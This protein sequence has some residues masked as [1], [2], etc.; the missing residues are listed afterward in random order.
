MCCSVTPGQTVR[1]S[2]TTLYAAEVLHQDRVAHV[3]GYQNRAEILAEPPARSLL[4]RI[5]DALRGA[6][7]VPNA[8]LLPFPAE[9]RSMTASNVV[10]TSRIPRVLQ[11]LALAVRPPTPQAKGISRSLA[12][13]PASV[14]VFEAAGIYTVVLAEDAREIPGALGAVRPERRPPLNAALFDAYAR[15]YPGWTMALC[16]FNNTEAALALPLVWWYRPA[17]P[18][19]LFLPG[20]DA[21]TGDLPDLGATVETDHTLA[22]S[23]HALTKGQQV[24]YRDPLPPEGPRW[25]LPRALGGVFE[26]SALNGDWYCDTERL[27]AGTLELRRDPPRAQA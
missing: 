10:D 6:S 1:F 11:D 27:R 21:H 22:V 18:E 26:G 23:S 14:Q 16:C 15:W 8:M 12:L 13:A 20:L 9:P 2:E 24:Y 4:Q 5:S 19:A 17:R 3:L 25:F 7:H